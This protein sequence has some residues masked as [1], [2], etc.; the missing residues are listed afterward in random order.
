MMPTLLWLD[1]ETT[2]LD[3]RNCGIIEA[4]A[5]LDEGKGFAPCVLD[6]LVAPLAGANWESFAQQMHR[7]SGLLGV[8]AAPEAQ[9]MSTPEA[10]DVLLGVLGRFAPRSVMLAGNSIHFDRSFIN[11]QMP[12]LDRELHYRHMDVSC[13]TTFFEGLGMLERTK[14]DKPHRARHDVEHSFQTFY[15]YTAMLRGLK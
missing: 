11:Q 3:P 10:E 2:G 13:L 9:P 15:R 8:L 4:A 14:A 1:F 5:L 7:D 6:S 12:R